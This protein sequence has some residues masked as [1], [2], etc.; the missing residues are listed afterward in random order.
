MKLTHCLPHVPSGFKYSNI[1][2]F[3][4]YLVARV[5]AAFT[6]LKLIRKFPAVEYILYFKIRHR[7]LKFLYYLFLS[8]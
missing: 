5:I 7:I 8:K 4:I 1:Y 2:N 3:I 6:C